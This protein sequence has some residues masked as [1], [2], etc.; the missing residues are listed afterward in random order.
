MKINIT[1][2]LYYETIFE[3]IGEII[4]LDKLTKF[5]N[6]N[7]DVDDKKLANLF[8]NNSTP[9]TAKIVY[10]FNPKIGIINMLQGI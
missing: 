3:V 10:F 4:G 7:P 5:F 9:A 1:E 6:N 8:E 2:L